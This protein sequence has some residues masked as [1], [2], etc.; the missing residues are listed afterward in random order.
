MAIIFQICEDIMKTAPVAGK[1]VIEARAGRW[2][3]MA[4]IKA[5]K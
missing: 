4:K 5:G 3:Q 1:G 2:F